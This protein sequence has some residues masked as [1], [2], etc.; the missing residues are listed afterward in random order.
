MPS[1]NKVHWHGSS[2]CKSL[3]LKR[4]PPRSVIALALILILST[5]ASTVKA[6]VGRTKRVLIISTGSRFAPGFRIVDQQLFQALGQVMSPRIE[7]YAENLNVV[8]FSAERF[9][10]IFAEYLTAKYAEHPPDAVIL[11][12]VGNLETFGM[13][14]PDLFPGKPIIIAGFTEEPI[15]TGQFGNLVTGI[16]QRVNPSAMLQLILRL[17]PELHRLVVIGGTAKFDRQVL[18]RVK[19]AAE[20]FKGRIR[21]D[22]RDNL[23]MADLRQAV[24]SLPPKTAILFTT[25]FRD[26]LGQGYVSSQVGRWITQLANVPVYVMTDSHLGTGAVGGAVASIEAFG[27]RAGELARLVLTGTDIKSLP[28]EIRTDTVPMFDWRALKRWG[29]S[30]SR[31]PPNSIVKFRP[32]SLWEE[33]RWYIIGTLIII[34]VQSAMII[35][36]LL[37]RRRRRRVEAEL[38]DSRLLMELSAEAGELGLWSRDLMTGVI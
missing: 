16:V 21:I 4:R 1:V 25:L 6:Q 19:E 5:A 14:L 33:S 15:R 22:F 38:R 10:Q 9:R 13:L 8:Q 28:L 32:Q 3:P 29:I 23:S 24:T 36:L 35:D 18:R 12:Y 7:T 30:E 26:G 2:T 37:Q 27:K 31:L 17:Q 11:V 20:P 34:V